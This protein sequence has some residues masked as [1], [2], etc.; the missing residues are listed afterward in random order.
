MVDCSLVNGYK[1]LKLLSFIFA[2]SF[3]SEDP[4]CIIDLA[5]VIDAS[6]S[7]RDDWTT[8]L[9]F[10]VNVARAINIGPEG[11]HIALIQFGEQA[12]KIFDFTEFDQTPYNER[13]IFNKILGI[14]RPLSSE[15]TFINRGLKKANDEVFQ[16]Q[17]GM[18]PNVKQ[19]WHFELT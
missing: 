9:G 3:L 12:E 18:R 8:L 19:V 16:A 11:S 4:N 1:N 13:A 6:G 15:R 7:V 10:V 17:F 2:F 5:F 14:P